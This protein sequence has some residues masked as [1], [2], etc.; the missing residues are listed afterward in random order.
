MKRRKFL[1]EISNQSVAAAYALRAVGQGVLPE[2][3]AV[4]QDEWIDVSTARAWKARWEKFILA[5]SAKNRYCDTE[6]AEEL[7]WLVSPFLNGFYHGYLATRD[8]KWIERLVDW[9]DSCIKRAVTEPDGYLGWP[10]VSDQTEGFNYDS[11]LGEAMILRPMVRAASEILNTPVL[12]AKWS[13]KAHAYL[14]LAERTFE[15]WDSRDAWRDCPVGGIWVV[16][17]FGIDAASGKWTDGF[18]RRKRSEEHTSE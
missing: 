7:G 15:K 8:P 5:D 9:A 2:S 18:Q 12:K 10:K 1:Q 4:P 14:D 3:A 16:Q 13:G 11:M 17:Y 6:M